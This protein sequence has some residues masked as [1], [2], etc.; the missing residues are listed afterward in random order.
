MKKPDV[1]LVTILM[2]L[3]IACVLV[4]LAIAA[5]DMMR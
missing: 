5:R 2:L 4:T 1:S 3:G